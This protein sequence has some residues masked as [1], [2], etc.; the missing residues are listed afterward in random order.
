MAV[1]AKAA[2]LQNRNNFTL[3]KRYGFSIFFRRRN[4]RVGP[5]DTHRDRETNDNQ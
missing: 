3:K 4:D 5:G 2:L 1:T